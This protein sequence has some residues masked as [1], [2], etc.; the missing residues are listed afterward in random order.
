MLVFVSIVCRVAFINSPKRSTDVADDIRVSNLI[1]KDGVMQF[2]ANY[3][4]IYHLGSQHPPLYPLFLA[5]I[6]PFGVTLSYVKLL[7]VILSALVI[8]PTYFIGK[9]L[10]DKRKAVLSALLMFALPC[11]FL[12]SLHAVNDVLIML[13]SALFMY[14][15]ILYTKHGK[16][17]DGLLAVIIMGIGLLFKYTI[18]IFYLSTLVFA[19]L[20]KSK[21]EE[22]KVLSKTLLVIFG[23]L[24][25]I[26]PWII[27][28]YY[29]GLFGLQIAKLLALGQ[30]GRKLGQDSGYELFDWFLFLSTSVLFLSPTNT[31]LLLPFMFHLVYRRK[32]D[33]KTG[34]LTSWVFVPF[35]FYGLL[36]PLVRYW[37]ISFPALTLIIANSIEDLNREP[38]REKIFL[39]TFVCSLI[40][41]FLI[42]YVNLIYVT[43]YPVSHSLRDLWIS[44]GRFF[45]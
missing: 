8:I 3:S 13:F 24:L 9:E 45:G 6:F 26:V 11:P 42:S 35:I 28:M 27:Y 20:Y 7:M 19:I 18:A 33:W 14:F 12:M 31:V 40:L 29:T 30:P 34:L 21:K 44:Y 15:F 32:S 39:T 4:T 43:P 41:C 38:Y 17:I 22:N 36:Q 16:K 1:L 25:F 10:Y 5:A 2:L 23:S 37:I